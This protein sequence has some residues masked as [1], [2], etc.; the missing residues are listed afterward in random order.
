MTARPGRWPRGGGAVCPPGP[1]R[2]YLGQEEEGCP[3]LLTQIPPP[4]APQ[5]ALQGGAGQ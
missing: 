4:E 3:F 1:P 5:S 2:G